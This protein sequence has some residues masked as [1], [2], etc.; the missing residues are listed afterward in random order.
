MSGEK[1][2]LNQWQRFAAGG[3]ACCRTVEL[4]AG[5]LASDTLQQAGTLLSASAPWDALLD[6]GRTWQSA[7][8]AFCLISATVCALQQLAFQQWQ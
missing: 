4:H 5:G 3:V 7:G 8:V 2:D 1:Y 6:Q